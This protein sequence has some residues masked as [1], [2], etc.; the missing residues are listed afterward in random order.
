MTMLIHHIT[1]IITHKPGMYF[2]FLIILFSSALTTGNA[3]IGAE[4]SRE[5]SRQEERTDRKL[6]HTQWTDMLPHTLEGDYYNEFWSYHIFLEED[7]HLHITF[8]MANFGSFKSPV[9]GGKLF[10]SNFK[11]S[12]YQVARE[13]SMDHLIIDEEENKIRLHPGRDIYLT[14]KLPYEHHIY[15][16]TS[17]DGVS[18]LVDLDFHDIHRGYTL[19]D[20][21]FRLENEDMGIF[22]H[23]PRASVSGIVAIN[24]DTLEVSGT[25]YMDHTFQ[26][27]LS[28]K[29]VDKGFRH[30]THTESGFQVGYYLVPKRRS[31]TDVIGFAITKDNSPVTLEKP[32]QITVIDS[33]RIGV[34][35]VPR[36]VEIVYQ[37]GNRSVFSRQ[38]D[39]QHVSFLEEIGGIRRRLVRSFLGGEIIEY[40]GTGIIDG[41]TPINYNFFLVH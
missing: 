29:V 39:F 26:T 15:Y 23:I 22:M 31:K 24:D 32:E 11:G 17:K 40:V 30:I 7:L 28:S 4:Q 36:Y 2:T 25:A 9:S 6:R 37:S 12:N 19:G 3:A 34:R 41:D 27:N 20:G 33:D 21:I 10:V 38:V 1:R 18:Y 5:G 35:T 8:S 13:Y 16:R 14:G